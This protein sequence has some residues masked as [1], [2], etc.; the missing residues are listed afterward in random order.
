MDCPRK[1]ANMLVEKRIYIPRSINRN[2]ILLTISLIDLPT[3]RILFG[4]K[5]KQKQYKCQHDLIRKKIEIDFPEYGSTARW[6]L[7]RN[8]L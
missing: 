5:T 2:L 4:S 7:E 8:D 6:K 1:V 3:K